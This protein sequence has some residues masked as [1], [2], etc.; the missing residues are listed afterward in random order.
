MTGMTALEAIRANP[1]D[2][3]AHAGLAD[4]LARRRSWM[5]AAA[6]YRTAMALGGDPQQLGPRYERC[7]STELAARPME[8][9]SH[10]MVFRTAWLGRRLRELYPDGKFSLLDAGGGDGRLCLEVPDADYV[11]A[12]PTTNGLIVDADLQFERTF[13]VVLCCHVV[14]H[15]PTPERAEFL[16]V[17]TAMSTHRVLLLNPVQD[18]HTDLRA[19]QQLIVDVTGANWAREH[20]DAELPKLADLT[21]YCES[22]GFPYT[23]RPNGSKAL[24][25]A[26]VFLDHYARAGGRPADVARINAMFNAIDH[27]SLDQAEWPNAWF[28]E[29]DT[30][31]D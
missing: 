21:G 7:A 13:D 9:G 14:E 24:S 19:W 3:R 2:A 18:E 28:V 15:I 27:E 22:R 6:Q 10:N 20:L 17:L 25:L 4:D 16:D 23:V 29:I 30:S 26:V 5:R 1:A 11:L 31:A 12:E 8:A